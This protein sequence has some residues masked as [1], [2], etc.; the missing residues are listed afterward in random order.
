MPLKQLVNFKDL[1]ILKL[2]VYKLR[3]GIKKYNKLKVNFNFNKDRNTIKLNY[4]SNNFS[5]G[6]LAAKRLTKKLYVNTNKVEKD[7]TLNKI[8]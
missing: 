8:N 6:K 1:K 4:K 2:K 5:K 3:I 7:F